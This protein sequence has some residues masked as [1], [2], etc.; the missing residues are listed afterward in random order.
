MGPKATS[1]ERYL[2]GEDEQVWTELEALGA[3]V[4]AEPLYS[5]A[6]TV[7]RETMRRVRHTIETPIPQLESLG[8][9]F[10]YGRALGRT[11]PVV[12]PIRPFAS[13]LNQWHCASHHAGAVAKVGST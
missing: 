12:S 6:L 10:G 7:A 8:Y 11:F 4:R 3:A 9:T 2:D 1:L 13:F 5:D